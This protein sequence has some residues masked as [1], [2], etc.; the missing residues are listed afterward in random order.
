MALELITTGDFEEFKKQLTEELKKI[1]A[2]LC[3]PQQK[4]LKTRDVCKLLRASPG[5]V[6]NLRK[7]RI[8]PFGKVGGTL[9]YNY[10][11]IQRLLNGKK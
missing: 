3:Q 10:E 1:I 11:D 9:Y 8:L 2:A 7:N 4:V 5:T 6:Q